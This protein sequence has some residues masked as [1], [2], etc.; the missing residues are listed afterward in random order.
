MP[1]TK[2]FY[3]LQEHLENKLLHTAELFLLM[4]SDMFSDFLSWREPERILHDASLGVFY[5]GQYGEIPEIA[6]Q[7]DALEEKGAKV[8][9]VENPV[10]AISS[11]DLLQSISEFFVK[12]CIGT[13]L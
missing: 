4:G 9:L 13:Y 8:Y 12:S 6:R 10:T 2:D 5:R 1:M 3:R 7:K 11:T